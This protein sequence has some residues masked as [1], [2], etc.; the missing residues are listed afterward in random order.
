[1][2][3]DKQRVRDTLLGKFGFQNV[4]GSKHGR[5]AFFYNG[6]KIATIGFSRGS[7]KDLYDDLLGVMAKEIFVFNLGFF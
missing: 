7:K 6:K 4:E 3:L 5:I 1:M 2:S